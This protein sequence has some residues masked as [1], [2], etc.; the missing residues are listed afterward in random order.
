M[1]PM[2]RC[3]DAGWCWRPW[4]SLWTKKRIE[5]M[6]KCRR[7]ADVKIGCFMMLQCVDSTS[8]FKKSTMAP[9][10]RFSDLSRLSMKSVWN[11]YWNQYEISMKSV[12]KSIWNQYEIS[13]IF[14]ESMKMSLIPL[15]IEIAWIPLEITEISPVDLAPGRSRSK[16]GERHSQARRLG[17]EG[18]VDLCM[19]YHVLTCFNHFRHFCFA[20][21]L[22]AVVLLFLDYRI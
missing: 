2:L 18:S 21:F 1:A 3:S 11:Q 22:P 4:T 14:G 12:L 8:D 6:P 20:I 5:A 17:D 13:M 16:M 15:E 9:R 7:V 10:L 19:F